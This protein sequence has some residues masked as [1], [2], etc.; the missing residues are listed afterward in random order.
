VTVISLK[1]EN[2][3]VGF[4]THAD[5]AVKV[6]FSDGTSL[7]LSINY[8]SE[9][10]DPA[11]LEPGR[12]L[13]SGEEEAFRFAAACYR[14]ERIALRL[15]ARAEQNSLG[16]TAKLQRRHFDA[17]VVKRVVSCL[18]DRNLLDDGRYAELWIRSRLALRKPPT[19]QLLLAALGK[20]GIDRKASLKAMELV[21]DPQT[22]YELLL[23]YLEKT[24]FPKDK[25]AFSLKAQLKYQGFSSEVLDRYFSNFC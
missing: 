13:S 9:G 10:E 14:A 8:L 18:L 23:R 19:P 11:F 3:G 12:E 25:K 15:I 6:D 5:G 21:V 22:E 20:R 1:T 17:V 24:R 4:A 7:L 16:L 2:S